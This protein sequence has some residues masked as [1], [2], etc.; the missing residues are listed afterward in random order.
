MLKLS[1]D[2]SGKIPIYQQIVEQISRDISL[3]RLPPGYQLPTVRE[4]ASSAGIAQGTIKHAYDLLEQAGFINKTRGSGTFV[5]SRRPSD[6][7]SARAQA[8][9]AIDALFDRLTALSFTPRDIRIFLDL[10]LRNRE[11][12]ENTVCI[13]AVD[14]APEALSVIET[15]LLGIPNTEV[16]TFLLEEI[17]RAPNPFE[18]DADMVITLPSHYEELLGKMS[19]GAKP[20]QV[21]MVTSTATALELA[22]IP[23]ETRLGI[24]CESRSFSNIILHAC[25]E[26]CRTRHPVRVAYFG[27][28]LKELIKKCGRLILP[29]NYSRFASAEEEAL[30]N[31]CMESHQPVRYQYQIDQGSLLFLE[32]RIQKIY[33]SFSP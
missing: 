20:A 10:K 15:Q 12:Q 28:P 24:I 31:S 25:G 33:H 27:S 32:E 29:P 5:S 6:K 26:Y 4:L 21:S 14:S 19:G 3:E 16:Y 1:L 7:T 2:N 22:S 9:E 8:M 17:L 30:I 11:E 13:A 23:P 18:A